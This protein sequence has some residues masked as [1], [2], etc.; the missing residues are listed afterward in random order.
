MASIRI[1]FLAVAAASTFA[2]AGCGGSDGG[3]G[4]P[5]TGPPPSGNE[6]ATVQ[7]RADGDVP[8]ENGRPTIEVGQTADFDATAR[9][10]GGDPVDT[11][12]DWF[13]LDPAVATV[14][15]SGTATGESP[16]E[17]RIVAEAENGVADTATLAVKDSIGPTASVTV[18][19][20]RDTVDV[21][22]QTSFEAS[23]VD[24]DGDSV[25]ASF[26]WTS[27]D[28][29]VATVDET[30][31]ATGRAV[32]E[33]GIV[34]EAATGERDT[35]TLVVRDSASGGGNGGGGE[36]NDP[37]VATILEPADGEAF[38]DETVIQFRGEASDPEEGSLTG[39]SLKWRSDI[40]GVLG[41]GEEVGASLQAGSHVISLTATDSAGA[42]DADTVQIEVE[43]RPDLVA[44]SLDLLPRGVLTS[45]SA[46]GEAIVTNAGSD[47][48]AY[49]WTV[50]EGTTV[51]ASGE[52]S[53]LAAGATDTIPV[54]G[55]GTFAA[56]AHDLRLEVDTEDAVTEEDED[57]NAT[58]SRLESR[59]SGFDIELQFLGSISDSLADE[60]R[61]E[62]DRWE[63][64]IIGD[65]RD[66]Q[67]DSLEIGDCVNDST[68]ADR[69]EP[70]DDLLVLVKADSIDGVGG[71]LAQA[72]PCF[73][74]VSDTDPEFP[75][76]PLVGSVEL[77]TADVDR[78]R[79]D[80]RLGDVILHELAH[81]LGFSGFMWEF[82]GSGADS[83][84]PHQLVD[85]AGSGDPRFTGPLTVRRYHAVGGS[86]DLVP[87]E[88]GGGQGTAGSHWR[89]EDFDNELMT[90]FINDG[91]NPL[92]VVTIASFGDMFY[93][94]DLGEADAFSL[95]GGGAI[96][97]AGGSGAEL[98]E[99][100]LPPLYGVDE[101]GRVWRLDG[102]ALRPVGEGRRPR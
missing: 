80:G 16:G 48:G 83:I 70:I 66:F 29:A 22:G 2:L 5:P 7:V 67:P 37:P 78:L 87:I 95:G 59:P 13:S 46:E 74:R 101:S 44:A 60:V 43:D 85:G 52:R 72:G 24:A 30:G 55:L 36:G 68:V 96:R 8:T 1:T 54:T 98:H 21:G 10:D 14:D 3:D 71:V 89:E 47:A 4:D 94:V 12:F 17:A 6:V 64:A 61:A 91:A 62:R 69:T 57:N 65:L 40:D 99:I 93:A 18:E 26:T 20:S 82:Q 77:D 76:L 79:S 53:G 84:G 45:Q 86:D 88:A 100:V 49:R 28:T 27:L 34:A 35:A 97:A 51:L 73:L 63:R 50:S 11:S 81:A 42:T 38:S 41:T 39:S 9:D 33:A 92:S 58:T 56:G 32:G 75:S 19:P 23:A 25:D 15:D 31:T 102:R 90:G